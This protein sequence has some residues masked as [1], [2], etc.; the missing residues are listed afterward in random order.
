MNNEIVCEL[1][2][3]QVPYCGFVVLERLWAAT[4]SLASAGMLQWYVMK[5]D[6]TKFYFGHELVN[7][8]SCGK[9]FF[10]DA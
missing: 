3:L 9:Q 5:H 1:A 2:S 7:I 4:K 6:E 10:P 8:G